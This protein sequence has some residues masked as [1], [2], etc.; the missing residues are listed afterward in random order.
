MCE[1]VAVGGNEPPLTVDQS[2]HLLGDVRVASVVSQ[3]DEI[4]MRPGLS[5]AG[6]V[7][8]EALCEDAGIRVGSEKNGCIYMGIVLNQQQ[9]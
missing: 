9:C 3:F 2:E 4:E 5:D 6:R 1:V 8:P 7:S